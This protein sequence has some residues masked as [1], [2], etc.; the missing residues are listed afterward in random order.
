MFE[1]VLAIIGGNILTLA[2]LG[3]LF[4]SIVIHWLNKDVEKYKSELQLSALR[5]QVSYGGIFQNQASRIMELYEL[6]VK[7][8]EV[9]YVVVHGGGDTGR[10][11]QQFKECWGELRRLYL[12][13]RILL[14]ED[15]DKSLKEFTEDTFFSVTGYVNADQRFE[16]VVS[17]EELEELSSKQLE[18]AQKLSNDIPAMKEKLIKQ[19]RGVIGVTQ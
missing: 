12:K 8:D 11:N 10:R 17:D 13:S 9:Q 19:L 3:F 15:L 2:I 14:P 1:Q 4:R 18:I 5:F 7:L 16:R 6:I